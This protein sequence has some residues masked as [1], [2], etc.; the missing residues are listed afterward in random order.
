METTSNNKNSFRTSTI[1]Y[2]Q[3]LDN[4]KQAYYTKMQAL[5]QKLEDEKNR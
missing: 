3:N 4:I 5:T 2:P 1:N